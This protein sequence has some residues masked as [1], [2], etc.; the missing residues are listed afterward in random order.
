M[1]KKFS[2][3][4]LAQL[5]SPIFIPKKKKKK[6]DFQMYNS[7]AEEVVQSVKT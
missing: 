5:A 6:K 7:A 1:K 4:L 3:T 2:F